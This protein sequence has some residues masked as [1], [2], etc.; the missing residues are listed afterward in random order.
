MNLN[1]FKYEKGNIKIRQ[2]K[3]TEIEIE[4]KNS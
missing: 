2:K 4:L 1:F 3:E